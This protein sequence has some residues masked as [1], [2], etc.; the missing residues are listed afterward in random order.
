MR[1]RNFLKTATALCFA[2]ALPTV[3]AIAQK[4]TKDKV[5]SETYTGAD[6][7]KYWADL[8]YKI[9]EPV[10][11]NMGKGELRKNMQ[12]GV[13][14][15]WDNNRNKDVGYLEAFGRLICG[16]APWL[17]LPEDNTGEGKQRKQL[18]EWTHES[19]KH[20]V[21]P[22]S[23]DYLVWSNVQSPQPLVDAA[24]AAQALI[25]AP[26][27]LWE[28]LDSITKQ[29]FIKEFK[30]LRK[31]IPYY[32][33][34]LLF[35]AT[36]EAF[37]MLIDEQCDDYRIEMAVRKINEWYQGDGW[38][39]DGPKFCMDYYNS[40][41]IQPMLVD[42]LSV[43]VHKRKRMHVKVY[44]DAV[45]RMQRYSEFLA[46][47]IS[48]EGTFPAFG[49]SLTYRV[50]AFQALGQVALME[51]LPEG[52]SNAQ[53]RGAL[54][55]VRRRMFS[56]EGNFNNKG[57]LDFGF[58]GSQPDIADSYTNTGSLYLTSVGFLPLGLPADHEFWAA[59]PEKWTSQKA[60]SGEPFKK[61]YAVNY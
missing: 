56:V 9:S 28:P 10:L 24:F 26:K 5:L 15:L 27:V 61:D 23:P 35:S 42:V 59:A 12:M 48:P 38:Y 40:F 50:G 37:L 20:S 17:S 19:L 57:Y 29:R 46:R 3:N 30:D 33:N 32:N 31:I 60:W 11:Y 54:T 22:D 13:P 47:M 16:L 51:K 21:N 58:A 36:I 1:R 25:R 2:T 6:D 52:I 39:S 18:I 45:Q 8:L 41:V 44:D 4:R 34:W 7:R 14:P 43:Y 55:A 53:A 49:R